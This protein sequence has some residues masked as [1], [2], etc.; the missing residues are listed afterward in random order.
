MR[1]NMLLIVSR[2]CVFD[3]RL[4]C[5]MFRWATFMTRLLSGCKFPCLYVMDSTKNLS[6]NVIYSLIFR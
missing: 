2:V 4:R 6:I 3:T 5:A 1:V